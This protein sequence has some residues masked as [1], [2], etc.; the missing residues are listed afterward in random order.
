MTDVIAASLGVIVAGFPGGL[1]VLVVLR[2][3]RWRHLRRSRPEADPMAVA[4][5]LLVSVGAGIPM[6]P[7]LEAAARQSGSAAEIGVVVRRSHRLGASV[8]LASG[9][10]P[11]AP[12]LRR[13][14]DA[15]LSGAPVEPAIR[16]YLDTERRRRHAAAIERARRLPVRLMIP[17]TL[18]VLPGFVLMVYGPELIGLVTDALGPLAP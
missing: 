11:L 9:E 4:A 14:A 18:L 7:A 13:L 2:T 10:G 5:R 1:V 12:L 8:A 15:A 6:I 16:S 17:M 3:I